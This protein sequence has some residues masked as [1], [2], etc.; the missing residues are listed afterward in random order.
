[1]QRKDNK[2][3]I[4][5]I[6]CYVL[7]SVLVPLVALGQLSK[8]HYLPPVPQFVY[9]TAHLYISTPYDEV[10]FTI[11]PIGQ[12]PSSWIT[13]SVNNTS[14]YKIRLDYT[15]IGANPTEFNSSKIFE[16]KGY[17]IIAN[18]EIYVSLRLKSTN[19][20]GSLVSK[21]LDGL[22]KTF[23]VGGMERQESD[24][25]SFFSIM[26]TKNNTLVEFDF[27]PNLQAQNSDGFIPLSVVLQ[28]NETYLGLFN[29]NNNSLFIGTLIKSNN[30]IVVNSGSIIG[31]FSNQII[32]SPDFFPGEEDFGYLNGSDMGFD[33]LVSLDSSVDATEYVLIKGDSF[34][35][36]ENA[37]IIADNDDTLIKLN[38]DTG[39]SIALNAG[40]HVF[41]EGDKFTNDPVAEISF[42]YLQSNK[43]IYV[44]QGTG[45][46]GEAEG[47][48]GGQRVHF[49]GANQGMF[50]V[51]PLSCTS[52]GD[53]ESI[54]RIDEVDENSPFNGS[55]FLLSSYG[56]TVEVNGQSISSIKDVIYYPDPIKTSTAEYQVHR[57]DNLKG[58]VS[59][60]GS[61][62]LYVSY[63][64]VNN[65]ATSGS[66]YSGFTLEPRIYPEL[67]LSTLGSC[68]NESGQSNVTLLLPNS[69]NYDSIKWQKQKNNGVWEYIFPEDTT[70]SP[71]FMPNEFGAYRLEV[72]V[73]C[74]A[75]NS[76]IYSSE[77]NVSVCPLDYDKDGIVDNIDLDYDNDGIFNAVESLGNFEIDLTAS[78]PVLVG[79]NQLPYNTP[80]LFQNISVA[81]GSFIPFP[82]G[83][84]T[85][86]LPPKQTNDDAVRFELAPVIPKS[87]NF[88]FD[89]SE[90]NT[91]PNEENTYYVL[92]SLDP[93][94]SIT[95]LDEASEIEI[96]IDNTFIG[97][98]QQYNSSKIIF[99]FSKTA[100][101]LTTT[102]FIFLASQSSGLAFTHHNDSSTDSVF[103]GRIKIIYLSSFS[104]SDELAD[105]FDL[106]SDGDGCFDVVEAGFL[107]P[108][109]NG[110]I[111]VDPLTYDDNTVTDRGLAYHDYNILP[112]DNDNNGVYEFQEYGAPAEISSSGGPVS[113]TICAGEIAT[114]SVDTSN[115]GAIFSW[116]IDGVIVSDVVD[117]DGLYGYSVLGGINT[118][119]L[120]IATDPLVNPDS[121][122]VNGAEIKVLVSHPTYACPVQ[123]ESGV[124]LN[125]LSNPNTPVLDPTYT[126]CFNDSPTILDLK[127]SIGGSI[128]V[129]LS[130]VGGSPLQ[131]DEP[132]KN[133]QTYYVE[134][135]SSDGCI[136]LT[137]AQTNIVIS[138][139]EIVSSSSEICS[140][141]DVLLTVNGVPQT[142]QDFAND[143]TDFELFLQ[144]EMS[145][146][147]LK[148]ESMAWTEA[149]GL[150]QSLDASASMYVINSKEEENAVYNALDALG[151]AGT[152]EIHFWLGLRQ[153][154]NLNPNNNVDEGWQWLDGR[155]LSEELANWSPPP[156]GG[157]YGEP[158]DSGG[159]NSQSYFE[160]GAEDYAQFD[161]RVNKTWNDMRDNSSGNGDS[162]PIF[163]FIGT[164]EVVWGKTDP[165][166]GADIIF[167]GIKTSSILRSPNETT[168]YFYEVT[169]NG[170]VCRVET[171][172]YVNPLPQLLPAN[173]M[174]LCDDEQD[175]NAYNG[176]VSGFD[177]QSQEMD[178]IGNDTALDVLFF[179]N[180]NDNA[181]NAID[182]SLMFANTTNPQ[183]LYYRIQNLNTGCVSDELG[184]FFLE[185]F[186]VPP[187][188][189]ISPHYECDD[190][191]S[192]SDT[193]N[194]TTF[195]LRLN[196]KRI[197][198]MLGGASDQYIISYHTSVTDAQD[199][200]S[201]GIESYTMPTN[202]NR[203][204][205]IYLRIIDTLTSLKC[206]NTSNEL[207]LILTPLPVIESQVINFEQCDEA[208]GVSDGI[209]LTNLRS[210]E[211]VI[212]SNF[213]NE[214]FSYYT[215]SSF[216]EDSKLDDPSTYYNVDSL[217]N[218]IMNSTIFVKVNSVLPDG[219]YAPN[220]SCG[221]Y[222][223][224]NINVVVSQIKGDFMLDFNACE[225]SPSANQDGKTQ[226][227]SN[228]FDILTSELLKEHPLFAASGVVIRYFP[229]LDD[230]ARKLNEIDIT[231][232][233]ENLNPIVNGMNWQDEIWASVEV[234]GLNTISCIGLKKVANLFIERLPTAYSV[235]PFRECDDDE[236]KSYSFDTTRLVQDLTFGQTN[237]SVSFFDSNYNLLFSDELPN[238]FNSTSQTLIARVENTPSEN[239]PSCYDETEILFIVDDTPNFNPIPSLV[240]CDDSDGLIDQKAAFD[241]TS[242]ESDILNGQTDI[243]FYYYDSFGNELPSPLPQSFSTTSTTIRVKLVSTINS[244][245]VDEGLIEFKVIEK[246]LFD[247]DE[248][249]VLCLNELSLNLEVRNPSDN[250]TYQWEYID[251][252]NGRSD[253]GNKQIINVSL[254]GTYEVTATTIGN[255]GCTTTKSIEVITSELA[256]LSEK[257][258]TISGFSGQENNVEVVV[259]NLGVGDYEFALDNGR[260]QDEPY[261]TQV[262]PGMRTVQV[263]DKIGCGVATIQVG[264]VGYYKYFSPNNDGINDTWQILGLK[265]TFNS[266]SKVY[267]Y[268][269]YGRFLKQLSGYEDFWDGNY[270][271][272][273]LPS[274]DYWFR[275][276]LEDGRIYT[277]HF[278]LI[279]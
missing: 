59:I 41:I 21:G 74:L 159:A 82:D 20:A 160:D 81:N 242:I 76:V 25:Y 258:V 94:E 235:L 277:G 174:I 185:V 2:L 39:S 255:K 27:D 120:T 97:G 84:F 182:E 256:K 36:I 100:V 165:V 1:M 38:G 240:L 208:D 169:T 195:D 128:E 54:A 16:N 119:T 139:P 91:V 121:M 226:F 132:L 19:H 56:S 170:E 196:D 90:G 35:S 122:I 72:I 236:D 98:F 163:E 146:Y 161:Y 167:D 260:F 137:R 69:E 49:Y 113:L 125:V 89:F 75:P 147:F 190:L 31:S 271:G 153:L 10:Q 180:E 152:N 101:G 67:N 134:A 217:G 245:C 142:A 259:D 37:L 228:I 179:L 149:Y 216:S 45:K 110:R 18:R 241:T 162:W 244:T 80:E 68:I 30:D 107:D 106:D 194:I 40:E 257:D 52:V 173:D 201:S 157:P 172:V 171:T 99:R 250:Y 183:Q 17:E 140:G 158:N 200:T 117:N 211:N 93:S 279:R 48:P 24:D 230:A 215:D 197:E 53:V 193:D 103:D 13:S 83:R 274:D 220:G 9:E 55:L 168:T 60:V 204:K 64:N 233:Y 184:S 108:D 12:P 3:N 61:E 85:S 102:S 229:S 112:N 272:K 238:P 227:S 232:D 150:I 114:F 198:A 143:N 266:L 203:R 276:E 26:A 78:P 124:F 207:D 47:N 273:P 131:N 7:T 205:T 164:T 278:S 65:A 66:F 70:D 33:Q 175:G 176:L 92:E 248:E 249:A 79:A 222:A 261:F 225:L 23:R 218:P 95:L 57:I 63:Y 111:G 214:K 263:R 14:S 189:D 130:E 267:I 51:P 243:M 96:F 253:V 246:P 224:I 34:N 188:I 177:L 155:L 247:L 77:V 86:N 43:N 265:T 209:V 166:T 133:E 264:V 28:K 32:D 138:N 151:I 42:L 154:S 202:D 22:G 186:P 129:F 178:I 270:Q 29:G 5:S 268:D 118:N 210:F 87:L 275:L 46:K 11:K 223:E 116:T 221:R 135:F 252:N 8:Q 88:A 239:T 213:L 126:F 58:D 269:R 127:N 219:V 105:A 251:E 156:N 44:F 199:P 50:F 237:V 187:V 148:R 71:E 15:Q 191:M 123:S 262:R 115:D 109:N 73:E 254:G 231:I 181:E 206:E 141:D 104:D 144:Y 6:T 136:S 234:E 62:E 212:S 4:A 145:S 192:G